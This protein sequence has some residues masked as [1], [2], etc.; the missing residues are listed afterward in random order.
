MGLGLMKRRVSARIH[1]MSRGRIHISSD[2]GAVGGANAY[3]PAG[4]V[5]SGAVW[6]ALG[7][8]CDSVRRKFPSLRRRS[9]Q[10]FSSDGAN[11]RIFPS[12]VPRRADR[13]LSGTVRLGNLGQRKRPAA[14]RS[15]PMPRPPPGLG[16]EAEALASLYAVCCSAIP[17]SF[18]ISSRMANFCTLPVTVIG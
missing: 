16:L 2:D 3:Q 10:P 7:A 13:A 1:K 11:S 6:K 9:T 4:L 14:R 15:V 8:K 18:I 12:E 5:I 17:S